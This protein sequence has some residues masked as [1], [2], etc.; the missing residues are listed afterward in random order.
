M[1]AVS[2]SGSFAHDVTSAK[3]KRAARMAARVR[4]SNSGGEYVIAVDDLLRYSKPAL[5][6]GPL[7]V[8]RAMA[9]AAN[10]IAGRLSKIA[11]ASLEAGLSTPFPEVKG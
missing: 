7:A 11:T 6:S 5:K 3:S 2:T 10:S 8:E 1:A 4:K 9:K